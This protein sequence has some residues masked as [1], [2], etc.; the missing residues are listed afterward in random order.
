MDEIKCPRCGKLLTN[1]DRHYWYCFK[2]SVSD[3]WYKDEG[4]NT[5][6]AKSPDC[7]FRGLYLVNNTGEIIAYLP[8]AYESTKDIIKTNKLLPKYRGWE[9]D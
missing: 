7:Y 9:L 6:W 5:M 3:G 8:N 4:C 1:S 2:H